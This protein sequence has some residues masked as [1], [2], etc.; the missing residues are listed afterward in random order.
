MLHH[1]EM[2]GLRARDKEK[3]ENDEGRDTDMRN[4]TAGVTWYDTLLKDE[5]GG[6][7]MSI[8]VACSW[9]TSLKEEAMRIWTTQSP[10]VG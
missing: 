2:T 4:N 8:Q 10:T 3:Q 7:Q 5:A 1:S 9:G 6:P